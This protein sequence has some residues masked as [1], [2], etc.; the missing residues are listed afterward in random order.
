[1]FVWPEPALSSLPFFGEYMKTELLLKLRIWQKE[2][3]SA[4][5]RKNRFI[6]YRVPKAAEQAAHT[7]RLC[8]LQP[9]KVKQL[10]LFQRPQAFYRSIQKVSV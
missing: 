10:V 1:M 8:V 7:L 9:R 6:L 4:F 2:P 3:L 5:M